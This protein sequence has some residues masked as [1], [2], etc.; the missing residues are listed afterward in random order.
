MAQPGML[1]RLI[2][3]DPDRARSPAAAAAL[4]EKD[5]LFRRMLGTLLVTQGF[6]E[7]PVETQLEPAV[8]ERMWGHLDEIGATVF[9]VGDALA[10]LDEPARKDVRTKLG[11]QPDLPMDLGEMI[12]AQ[13][14]SAG[15]SSARRMQLRR[16][17]S[18]SAFRMRHGDPGSIIDEY[19]GKVERVRESGEAHGDALRLSKQ[20]GERSFWRYQHLLAQAPGAGAP[21]PPPGT[22]GTPPAPPFTPPPVAPPPVATPPP[23]AV[24]LAKPSMA[25]TLT[26]NARSAAN[27]G[28]C[29]TV[30]AL[31]GRVMSLDGAYYE[32]NFARDPIIVAC[33][34]GVDRSVREPV[35][36]T[37]GAQLAP[38]P[39]M[40]PPPPKRKPGHRGMRAGG[41]LLGIGV[42]TFGV[43]A[44]IISG[45]GDGAF[46]IGAL[47]LTA[48]ALLF[49][50]G[51][52][53]LLI[54]AIIAATAD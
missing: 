1:H 14:A 9:E 44:A 54:S 48:G 2:G 31:R 19:V 8:Q 50:I 12:D 25:E 15:I 23:V 52:I 5:E 30:E 41:Y 43:S 29:K 20:L 10:A 26:R 36:G 39:G 51:L 13:A 17:M 42:L 53:T 34:Q 45:S 46:A 40:E 7:L 21:L 49:A 24:P 16:M 37:P 22:P 18:Q 11:K 35:P 38:P 47:G 33:R 4:A 27:R 6:R 28:D 3:A 32:A